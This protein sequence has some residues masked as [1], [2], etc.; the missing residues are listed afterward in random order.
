MLPTSTPSLAVRTNSN[1]YTGF[2][3]KVK[4]KKRAVGFTQQLPK[5]HNNEPVWRSSTLGNP[6]PDCLSLFYG[7]LYAIRIPQSF[8]IIAYKGNYYGFLILHSDIE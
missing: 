8:N 1:H 4:H 2:L 3:E 6:F 7:A 5:N